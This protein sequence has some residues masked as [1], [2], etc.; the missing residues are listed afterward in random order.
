MVCLT[1]LAGVLLSTMLCTASVISAFA[2]HL[3]ASMMPVKAK[4]KKYFG[5]SDF[6]QLTPE[7]GMKRD[8]TEPSRGT[9]S[10]GGAGYQVGVPMSVWPEPMELTGVAQRNHTLV[11]HSQLPGWVQ[12]IT[13]KGTLTLVLKNHITT[14]MQ[15]YKG[16][17]YAW[18]VVNEIFSEDGTQRSSVF[19]NVLGED[20]PHTTALKT[21]AAAGVSEVA[22]TELDIAGASAT[23]YLN[24]VNACL[25]VS[26]CVGITVWG[27]SDKIRGPGSVDNPAF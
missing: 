8:A 19:Y 25:E 2:R 23:D 7:N 10:F 21:L 1:S 5:T 13:D 24:V 9:F 22:I 14:I 12:G 18:D 6:G 27:F 11:W 4:S 3:R 16:K 17:V 15:R 20:F 26:K